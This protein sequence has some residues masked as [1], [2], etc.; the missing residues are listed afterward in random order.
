MQAMD[1]TIRL[2]TA[3]DAPAARAVVFPVLESYGL[4]PE[5]AG[6]DADLFDLEAAYFRC[7]GAFWVAEDGRGR[8]VATCGLSP[9]DAQ[10]VELRKMYV[11]PDARR[12]GLASRLLELALAFAK[13]RGFERVELET[14]SVLREAIALYR[15]AGFVPRPGAVAVARCDQAYVLDLRSPPGA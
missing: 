5:P 13:A 2:A 3:A 8:I 9:V 4:R 6:T 1:F 14:A 11:L 12:R 10:A 7:G 15:K